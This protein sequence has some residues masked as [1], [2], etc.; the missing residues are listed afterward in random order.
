MALEDNDLTKIRSLIIEAL[1][2][3]VLPKFEE[4]DNRLDGIDV[5]LDRID[6]RLDGHDQQFASL[7]TRMNSGF[8]EMHQR[9]DALEGRV[10]AMENDIKDLYSMI[11]DLQNAAPADKKFMKLSVEKKI[12]RLNS[13]LVATAKQAGVTLPR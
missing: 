12:L 1:T 13:D 5:R 2:D 3:V 8:A 6:N 4:I 9:F 7:E 10:E 11:S